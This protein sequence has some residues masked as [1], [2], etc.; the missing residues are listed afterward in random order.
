MFRLLQRHFATIGAIAIALS[1]AALGQNV[2][3]PDAKLANIV[4][5]VALAFSVVG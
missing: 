1:I 3:P 4:G 5:T 2:P